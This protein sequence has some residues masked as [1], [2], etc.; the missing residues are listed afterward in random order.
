MPWNGGHVAAA[1][2]AYQTPLTPCEKTHSDAANAHAAARWIADSNGF[3]GAASD[4]DAG[5]A[6]A[7]AT[8][9]LLSIST[10]NWRDAEP[11]QFIVLSDCIY[12]KETDDSW[13]LVGTGTHRSTSDLNEL[14]PTL[15]VPATAAPE[16]VGLTADD[17]RWKDG[18]K[19][20]GEFTE[21]KGGAVEGVLD[22][23][24]AS[25]QWFI[26]YGDEDA[27]YRADVFPVLYLIAEA[28]DPEV[29]DR[30]NVLRQALADA[31]LDDWTDAELDDILFGL[32]A[33][34]FPITKRADA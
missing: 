4:F 21:G 14:G 29:V 31:R 13:W 5:S 12:R 6:H 27:C 32:D 30:R 22:Y 28:P 25:G 33:R 1:A 7:L 20:R 26:D 16:P 19:V 8:V 24:A 23:W 17:P 11:G 9:V 10:P 34:N 15:L 2:F 18:A 3:H